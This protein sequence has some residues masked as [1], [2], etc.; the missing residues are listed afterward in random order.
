MKPEPTI[1]DLAAVATQSADQERRKRWIK[2]LIIIAVAIVA[3]LA[4]TA[5]ALFV[6]WSNSP[7]KALLDAADYAMRQQAAYTIEADNTALRLQVGDHLY[8]AEGTVN[9]LKVE[10]IVSGDI[11]YIRSPNPEKLLAQ[12]SNNQQTTTPSNS[13]L[14]PIFKELQNQWVSINLQTPV[15]R[16]D[17]LSNLHCAVDSKDILENDNTSRQQLAATYFAHQFVTIGSAVRTGS[18]TS[19]DLS[20]SGKD[21]EAFQTALQKTDFYKSLTDCVQLVNGSFDAT[22]L[23]DTKV[24]IVLTQSNHLKSVTMHDESGKTTSISAD[25]TPQ[26]TI[27]VPS[28]ARTLDQIANELF[29]SIT[30]R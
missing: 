18:D 5:I 22:N 12:A 6:W 23:S 27:T 30:T 3:L 19:Y 21:L 15:I 4:A 13:L 11:L 20:L 17:E 14:A 26:T 2:R 8:R 24:T 16:S 29:K 9:G 10:A 7:Q 1:A 28:N 25:Y